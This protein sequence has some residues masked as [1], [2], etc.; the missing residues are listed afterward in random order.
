ML[1][2]PTAIAIDPTGNIF[3]SDLGN[4][5]IREITTD[6]NIHTIASNVSADSI[7]VDA[8]DSVYFSDAATNTVRK[9]LSNGTQFVIA[10]IPGS[11]GFSGDGGPGTSAQLNQPHGV[12]L[13]SS[14]NVY[15]ADSGNQVI[16]L[17]S[18]VSSSISV[19]NAASGVAV[20][21]TPGEIV[22]IFGAG[23]LGPS[24]PASAQPGNNGFYGA[25]LA[26][27]TV[28]FNGTN[29]V[30]L[31]T[32]ATQVSAIVP[33]SVAIG[34]IANVAVTY[35]GQTFSTESAIP[36]VA[37][38]PGVFTANST[39]VGQA[40]AVNQDGSIN[41]PSSP[42][43]AGSYISLYVTGEGQ[44]TPTG[45][46]GKPATAPFPKPVLGV[47]VKL[48]GQNVPV[49][50]AGGA[51]DLVAGLMQVNVQIPANLLQTYTGPVA[52]PVVVVVE[53]TASQA[54]VTIT[55]SQ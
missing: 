1:G 14:G 17:L 12:A 53:F 16:R 23:G 7:A 36:V 9:I 6:G 31:Y 43:P 33:Y 47:S 30:L 32:S 2:S 40:A 10:G 34:G 22:T 28:S 52:V 24:T 54:N 4:T 27:T 13:D 29:A 41:G 46:D 39:G 25:Q 42:A 37:T 38:V 26:G 11:S 19:V 3:I 49:T 51:P 55:V 18:P 50:Y 48:A 35:Q 20:S 8:A 21:I 45:V 5:N 44:T 15:V